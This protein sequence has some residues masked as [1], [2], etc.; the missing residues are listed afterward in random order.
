M[1]VE[2]PGDKLAKA[3]IINLFRQGNGSTIT[4]PKSGFEAAECFVDGAKR[5]FAE[6]VTSAKIDNRLPLV[7]DYMGAMVEPSASRPWM[8]PRAKSHSMHR[9]FPEWSTK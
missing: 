4:F 7:A 5:N 8:R 6:Y 1:H 9:S 2:L 3:N